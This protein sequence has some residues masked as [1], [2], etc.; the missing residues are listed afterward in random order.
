[1][2]SKI[3]E[4]VEIKEHN[5]DYGTTYYHNL[6]LEN[7]DMINIG[8]KHKMS[9]GDTLDNYEIIGEGHDYNKA[10]IVNPEYSGAGTSTKSDAGLTYTPNDNLKGI[11][12]GHAITNAVSL[13]CAEGIHASAENSKESIKTYA[14]MIYQI[15]EELNSEI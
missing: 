3:K 13:H 1:M 12:I 14:K 11:K 6:V 15:S 2:K 7:G 8:R 5:N 4:V 9:V 10:K